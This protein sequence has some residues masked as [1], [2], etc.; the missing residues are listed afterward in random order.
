MKTAVFDREKT[1]GNT[2]TSALVGLYFGGEVGF[3]ATAVLAR[4]VSSQGVHFGRAV[5]GDGGSGGLGGD[6]S[7]WTLV[8]GLEMFR[9]QTDPLLVTLAFHSPLLVH[10]L[11]CYAWLLRMTED[12]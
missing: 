4:G 11:A 10:A 8:G 3:D 9:K 1:R 7:K 6:R 2:E 5:R 12:E